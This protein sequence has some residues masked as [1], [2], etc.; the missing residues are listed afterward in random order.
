MSSQRVTAGSSSFQYD[1]YTRAIKFIRNLNCKY[2]RPSSTA[3]SSKTSWKSRKARRTRLV[4]QRVFAPAI[5]V[6]RRNWKGNL[7]KRYVPAN[8]NGAVNG[9]STIINGLDRRRCSFCHEQWSFHADALGLDGISMPFIMSR[10]PS[11]NRGRWWWRL[12]AAS[13]IGRQFTRDYQ[14]SRD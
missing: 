11:V 13:T 7:I 10:T 4:L 14:F 8:D 2:A 6:D 5:V 9:S 1:L 3:T 12:C